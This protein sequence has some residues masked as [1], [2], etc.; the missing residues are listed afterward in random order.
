MG[1][2]GFGRNCVFVHSLGL[3]LVIGTAL[4]VKVGRFFCSNNERFEL[5]V[6]EHIAS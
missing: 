4:P 2:I 5:S 3:I 1:F 6:E